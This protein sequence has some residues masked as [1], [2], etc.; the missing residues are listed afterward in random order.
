MILG[1]TLATT[2]HFFINA[3]KFV[4]GFRVDTKYYFQELCSSFNC[5]NAYKFVV[6]IVVEIEYSFWEL[7]LQLPTSFGMRKGFVLCKFQ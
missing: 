6:P 3:Y 1:P 4:L 7:W 2:F 5:F